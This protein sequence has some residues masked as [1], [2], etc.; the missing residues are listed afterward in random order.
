M[1]IHPS[2]LHAGPV[3]SSHASLPV[4][5]R[6]E[7]M[8]G[9]LLLFKSYICPITP[10]P[11]Q[12]PLPLSTCPGS[13]QLHFRPQS[14]SGNGR[15]H[16]RKAWSSPEPECAGR[17]RKAAVRT[18]V[19]LAGGGGCHSRRALHVYGQTPFSHVS[20]TKRLCKPITRWFLGLPTRRLKN[21][22][23]SLWHLHF[24]SH[25]KQVFR[26]AHCENWSLMPWLTSINKTMPQAR[27]QHSS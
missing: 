27:T 18:G 17:H 23:D 7:A 24:R 8:M 9:S 1:N 2:T 21:S 5:T 15:C 25:T 12:K 16:Y 14:V 11:S 3:T 6:C 20:L 26:K 22:S 4:E 13:A 10:P 19:Q